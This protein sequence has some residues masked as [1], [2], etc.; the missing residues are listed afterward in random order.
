[1]KKNKEVKKCFAEIAGD[2]FR[3]SITKFT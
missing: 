1:M 3:L 2:A